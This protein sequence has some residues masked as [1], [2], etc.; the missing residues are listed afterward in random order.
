MNFNSIF[1]KSFRLILL[2]VSIIYGIMVYTRNYLYDK[3]F[4]K[5]VKFNFPI[6]CVGNLV[7]GGTGK[8]TMIEYLAASLLPVYNVAT[9]SRGYKR[10]TRGYI[11]A[12]ANT[13][14]LEIGDE[15]MQFHLK[16]P[17]LSVAVGEQR[18][19]AVPH[20]LQDRPQT[21]VIL[22]D[23]AFQHREIRAGLNIVLT[24][25]G[26]L[27]THDFFLPSGDLRDQRSSVKRA[28]TIIV[29]KCPSS[30]TIEEKNKIEKELNLPDKTAIY[31][32][33]L[34]YGIPYHICTS[35]QHQRPI[36][37]QDE[38]LLVSGIANPAPLKDY[39]EKNSAAYDHLNFSDHHIFSLDDLKEITKRFEKINNTQKMILTTEKDAVR[40]IK[41]QDVLKQM[42]FFVLPIQCRFLFEE[43]EEFNT[44]VH[45]FI[46]SFKNQE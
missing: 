33:T 17:S 14:A 36:T 8:S 32:T 1:L 7:M 39:L 9:L 46:Q 21:E 3:N 23:D 31:F 10:R 25:Y 2:P 16:F 12:N 5:S 44:S 35:N 6:I 30:L 34:E 11:L 43:G 22:L 45:A 42:P 27:Y 38:I 41:Y 15:P 28:D 40:L 18:I 24:Q 37:N 19:I 20:I 13:S 4:F 29:T 26:D